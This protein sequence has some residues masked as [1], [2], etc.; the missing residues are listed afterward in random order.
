MS[1]M[2]AGLI[3]AGQQP[4]FLRTIG[5]ANALA[6][7]QNEI[8]RQKEVRDFYRQNGAALAGGDQAAL[9]SLAQFDPGASLDIQ[10]Q[11]LSMDATRQG[12]ELQRQQAAIQ[13][14]KWAATQS[15]VE[16]AAARDRTSRGLMAAG[17]AYQAGDEQAF[18]RVLQEFGVEPF[19]MA[20]F[21]A[22]A[23]QYEGVLAG[24]NAAREF[25]EGP[26]PADEYGRYA[27]EETKAGRKPLSRIEYAQAKKG[28]GFSVTTKDGT[29]ITYGGPQGGGS[30]GPENPTS[31]TAMINTIDGIL[32]DPAL[33]YSTGIMSPLQSVPGT[34]MKRFQ[35]RANQLG[36]QAFLQAFESLKGGGQITEIE[37]QKA[38]Q[39]I[40]RLD[41]AQS[42]QD[43]RQALTELR[44]ILAVAAARPQGW[45]DTQKRI[46]EA[47]DVIPAGDIKAMSPDEIRALGP[48]GL[49]RIPASELTGL[50]DEQWDALESI[51]G[52]Q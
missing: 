49:L 48:D 38:T 47:Q 44:S 40:G 20:Q 41:T 16:V 6:A 42:P 13:A 10:K 51:A 29:T 50:S 24:L 27:R 12:M 39:A 52:G 30:D 33:E 15:A 32:N 46:N 22:Q 1:R 36:G 37:G 26:K 17:A 31:A 35:T 8:Q 34:P 2:N 19:P 9:N 23:A 25:V 21:P 5:T 3:L 45:L 7:Q 28:K 43:Y 4:D 18:Q 11:R 14:Q